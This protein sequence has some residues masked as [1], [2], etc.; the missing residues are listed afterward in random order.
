MEL[1]NVNTLYEQLIESSIST[2][3][4]VFPN[5]TD[6]D[7][8]LCR[9]E[10]NSLDFLDKMASFYSS[11]FTE[12]DIKVLIKFYSSPT[13]Q[14]ALKKIPILQKELITQLESY[15]EKGYMR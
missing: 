15:Q 11:Q 7:I 14:K 10:M 8:E 2:F 1:I 5:I 4:R 13:G 3:K 9:K 6:E 12:E